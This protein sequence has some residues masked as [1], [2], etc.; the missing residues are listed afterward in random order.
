MGYPGAGKSYYM[1]HRADKC[2]KASLPVFANFPMKG[3]RTFRLEAP[4]KKGDPVRFFWWE[5]NASLPEGGE[6]I[7]APAMWFPKKG[8][9]L[10]DEAQVFFDSHNWEV[11]GEDFTAFFSQTRKDLITVL[12]ASQSVSSVS[13]TI[14]DR[15][16]QIHKP[17]QWLS[18]LTGFS[19]K[20]THPLLFVVRSYYKCKEQYKK[21]DQDHIGNQW[22]FFKFGV[23][24]IYDTREKFGQKVETARLEALYREIQMREKARSEQSA[25]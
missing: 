21:N 17:A 10:I 19:R 15:T 18:F 11:Y 2:M 23:A 24:N 16:H 8:L 4:K 14:R 20:G 25:R 6:F 5:V 3:A 12:W 1:A 22:I 9:V 13:K 7:E